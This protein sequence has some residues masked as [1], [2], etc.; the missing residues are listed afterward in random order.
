M[1]SRFFP[2]TKVTLKVDNNLNTSCPSRFLPFRTRGIYVFFFFFLTRLLNRLYVRFFFIVVRIKYM[3][4]RKHVRVRTGPSTAFAVSP[5]I[6]IPPRTARVT[7]LPKR[8]R[9]SGTSARDSRFVF[10][11]VR[12]DT[13]CQCRQWGR[14]SA[15]NSFP[16]EVFASR[17]IHLEII[18]SD[19]RHVAVA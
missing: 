10:F 4:E 19:Y 3:S 15:R 7:G 2:Q 17:T 6:N 13:R 12:F 18:S 8:P 1:Y 11:F 9:V 16:H 14:G 5:P